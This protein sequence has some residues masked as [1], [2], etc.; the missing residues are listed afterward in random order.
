MTAPVRVGVIGAGMIAQAAHLPNLIALP[1]RFTLAALADPSELTR[2]T[3][4][5][6][7]RVPATYADWQS[8][9]ARETLD[10]VLICAPHAVHAEA[11][12]AALEAGL[13]VFVE[14]PLCIDPADADRIIAARDRHRCV[15]QV[16]YMKRF[17]PAFERMA[18][19]L[20]A[21]AAELSFVDVVAYD[22]ILNKPSLFSHGEIVVGRDL[23][24]DVRRDAERSLRAQLLAAVGSDDL[25]E[26]GAFA[27]IYLDALIHDVNL[28]NGLLERMGEPLPTAIE[29]TS[30]W[31][32]GAGA[33]IAFALANGARWHCTFLWLPGMQRFHEHVALYFRD[34]VRTLTFAAPYLHKHPTIYKVDG[35]DGDARRRTAFSSHCPAYRSELEH[36]HDCIVDGMPCRTPAELGRFDVRLLRDA[37]ASS[38]DR[39]TLSEASGP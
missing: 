35:A 33:T 34:S 12:I 37:F 2:T 29:S 15:V 24:A 7:H 28:V 18:D 21:T 11:A 8:M 36:F 10:A 17:D 39:R 16:G 14:K 6:R 1:E 25:Q 4:A 26:V 23:P 13:H 3:V 20:P 19:E 9:I 30:F 22:P 31:G 32:D 27:T 38:R 5:A